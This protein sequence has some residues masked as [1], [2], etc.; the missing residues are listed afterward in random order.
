[1]PFAQ[2]S[3]AARELSASYRVPGGTGTERPFSR[4]SALAYAVTRLPATA[5]AAAAAMAEVARAMPSFAPATHLD[6][7]CGSGACLLAARA[8]WPSLDRQ[9]GLER[10][11]EVRSL[12]ASLLSE[13]PGLP[14][15]V[16]GPSIESC[17]LRSWRPRERYDLVTA[18]YSLGELEDARAGSLLALAFEA[19]ADLGMLVVI[20]PGTTAGFSRVRDWRER[21]VRAGGQV[22]APC[23]HDAACPMAGADWCHFAVRVERSALHR[24]LKGGQAPFEDEPFSYVA[25]SRRPAPDRPAARVLRHPWRAKGRVDLTLCAPGGIEHLSVR[26]SDEEY[27]HARRARWGSPWG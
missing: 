27:G 9:V 18:S 11:A 24:R 7:G 22:V 2:L 20:E 13:L 12:G 19:T 4:L 8:T 16:S 23:P 6:L 15:R 1:M 14:G 5:A 3:G 21:L 17:D 10:D 26:R 25:A